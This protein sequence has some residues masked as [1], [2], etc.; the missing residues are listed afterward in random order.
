MAYTVHQLQNSLANGG[1]TKN[2]KYFISNCQHEANAAITKGRTVDWLHV[3]KSLKITQDYD[4]SRVL[5]AVL[6][7]K[8]HV[9][10]KIGDDMIQ[11]EYQLAERLKSKR[12]FIRFFCYFTC[13][14]DY[15]EHPGTRKTMCKGHGSKMN[16]I[17]MPYY[18]LGSVGDYGWNMKNVGILRSVVQQTMLIV[19]S[20]WY[21]DGFIHGD[22]HVK[23]VLIKPN[24]Y[25][26]MNLNVNKKKFRV[27]TL[28]YSPVIMDFENSRFENKRNAFAISHFLMDLNKFFVTMSTFIKNLDVTTI[29]PI[30]HVINQVAIT[31]G[32]MHKL[33]EIFEL[34]E[35]IRLTNTP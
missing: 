12:G 29:F 5:K 28:G 23:N 21:E 27:E 7:S 25:S 17:L 24:H 10:A 35:N 6:K 2:L 18:E 34:C 31:M 3:E 20:S 11:R 15:L 9:I 30:S 33:N 13:D 19:F 1:N 32:D 26:H 8:K 16:I 14:D 4:K 22:L